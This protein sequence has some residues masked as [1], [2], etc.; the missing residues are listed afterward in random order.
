MNIKRRLRVSY[1]VMLLIPVILLLATGGVIRLI[2]DPVREHPELP[3]EFYSEIYPTL[4]EEP[5]KL[6]QA[7]YLAQLEGLTGYQGKINM[8]VARDRRVV[9]SLES[10]PSGTNGIESSP[11]IVVTD[12][13]FRFT[14]GTPGE[15]SFLVS[16]S[17]RVSGA[18]VSAGII[19]L[20][21]IALLLVTNGVLSLRMT[22]SITRPLRSLE[23]AALQIT[24]ADL[25]TPFAYDGNDEFQGVF[26]GFEEMRVRLRDSLK[27]QQRY[28]ANR[29]ELLARIS[30]DLKT[31]ITAI[32]GYIEGIRDGIADTPEKVSKYL[33]TVYGKSVLM[34]DLIDSLFLFSRLDLGQE[35]FR[36]ERV[37]LR[38]FLV[39][40][41]E[42]LQ[43][44]YKSME[45]RLDGPV[46]EIY[47][48]ADSTQLTRVIT[49]LIDNAS[50]YNTRH[51]AS[52]VIG[53]AAAGPT[54]LVIVR[55]NGP[56][57]PE[58]DLQRVFDSFYRS[59]ASRS[60]RIEG[61]GLGLSIARQIMIAH[62][63]AISGR[64]LEGGFEIR[65]ELRLASEE[66]SHH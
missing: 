49:N 7:D 11:T 52:V 43:Q 23:A 62:G 38:T 65:L 61:S 12:W 13:D 19:V 54:A 20:I 59:D 18:L 33:D 58:A 2:Y 64:N 39:D 53:V 28:E 63:G 8:Y 4:A 50:K 41:C 36:F 10:I 66:D 32:K 3:G 25:D 1:I 22:T 26:K 5:E 16:D 6:L 15:F 45:V 46:P 60:S 57:I 21:A 17:E 44:D 31:P 48:H 42:E 47:A 34:N 27:E 55:D 56:G 37:A 14:D 40:A 9:N 24:N 29:R 30:H 35:R 51:D